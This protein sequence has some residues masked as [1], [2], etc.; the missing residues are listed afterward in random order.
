[1]KSS[2]KKRL[3]HARAALL[4]AT[5]LVLLW[6][7]TSLGALASGREAFTRA[8]EGAL[9]SASA[10][11]GL[12]LALLV[13]SA[14]VEIAFVRAALLPLRTRGVARLQTGAAIAI[15]LVAAAS[16]ATL[17]LFDG[18]LRVLHEAMRRRLGTHVGAAIPLAGLGALALFA[19]QA[20]EASA[21]ERRGRLF[22]LA[23]FVVA[24]TIFALGLRALVPLVSGAPIL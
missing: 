6:N 16:V 10:R 19:F 23:G 1:M 17:P 7:L 22:S 5:L 8:F 15:L 2:T 24:L 12:G 9:V 18:D 3:S 14:V 21:S 11:F 4:A 20:V 13:S